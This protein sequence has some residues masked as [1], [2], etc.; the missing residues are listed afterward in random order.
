MYFPL[1]QLVLR[2]AC[3]Q[4]R[5]VA[6]KFWYI[7]ENIFVVLEEQENLH[8][9]RKKSRVMEWVGSADILQE[10]LWGGYDE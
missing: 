1:F 3:R 10:C 5:A 9:S 6:G 4:R 7:L 2:R 8:V